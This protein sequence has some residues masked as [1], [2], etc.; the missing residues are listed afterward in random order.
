MDENN[1]ITDLKLAKNTIIGLSWEINRLK[2]LLEDMTY[3]N[4]LLKKQL[5]S[6]TETI[7]SDETIHSYETIHKE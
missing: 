6:L 3:K 1:P 5:A 2:S 4:E 7:H